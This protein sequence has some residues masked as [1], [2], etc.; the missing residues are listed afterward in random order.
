M[1]FNLNISYLSYANSGSFSDNF[2]VALDHPHLTTL[3]LP[4]D[5]LPI[6]SKFNGS[7]ALLLETFFPSL[8]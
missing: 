5:V 1:G 4:P 6:P 7:Y 8:L 3:H 2:S